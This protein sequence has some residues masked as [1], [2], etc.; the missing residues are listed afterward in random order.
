[1]YVLER[2]Y[3]AITFEKRT[4]RPIEHGFNLIMKILVEKLILEIKV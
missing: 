3:V 1:M 4:S 2:V